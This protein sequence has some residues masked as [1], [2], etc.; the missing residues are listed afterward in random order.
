MTV[1]LAQSAV[2]A[3]LLALALA[4]RPLQSL[5][6][7]ELRTPW[8]AAIVLLP[9][10]WASQRFLPSGLAV[11]LSGACLLVMMFGWPLA[12]WTCVP[13]ALAA[14]WLTG[15]ADGG[16]AAW[17][18]LALAQL[19]WVGIVPASCGLLVG[20]GVRHVLPKHLFVYILGRGFLGTALALM[21]AALLETA[22]VASAAQH[23]RGDLWLA[24]A[25]IAWGEAFATG[26][27]T[28]TFVAFRPA[29]M[30]T[31]SDERYLPAAPRS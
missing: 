7:A 21:A 9:L 4:F 17:W 18:S 6:R 10:L 28:A 15:G 11:H 3:L 23:T 14:A 31:Y 25:L 2:A 5:R 16:W 22:L 19:L 20:M 29:W 27:L 12:V 26:M 30:L 24:R 13:I 8:L 1:T